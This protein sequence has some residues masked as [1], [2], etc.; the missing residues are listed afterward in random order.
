MASLR[1]AACYNPMEEENQREPNPIPDEHSVIIFQMF[2]R[3]RLT[4]ERP[5][6]TP[7][8]CLRVLNGVTDAKIPMFCREQVFCR[9]VI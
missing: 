8:G 2:T 6:I 5:D 9:T 3:P 7:L 1:T 4:A